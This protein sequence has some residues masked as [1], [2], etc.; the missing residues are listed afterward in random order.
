MPNVLNI[1][2][3]RKIQNR[4]MALHEWASV[5]ADPKGG[6]ISVMERLQA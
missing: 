6:L 5:G 4:K 3:R 2:L 1:L